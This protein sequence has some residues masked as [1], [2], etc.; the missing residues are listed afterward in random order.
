MREVLL[1]TII[2]QVSS[3]SE[4]DWIEQASGCRIICLL[5]NLGGKVLLVGLRLEL[6]QAWA[7]PLICGLCNRLI[8]L[9]L[10]TTIIDGIIVDKP[11]IIS[12]VFQVLLIILINIINVLASNDI[13]VTAN[14][15][16]KGIQ[17]IMMQDYRFRE[18]CTVYLGEPH[19]ARRVLELLSLEVC[20]S[21]RQ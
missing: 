18:V 12:L 1:C 20:L 6:Y 17:L 5:R 11:I 8:S 16:E 14:S 7:M 10:S 4:V 19:E 2:L 13:V 15:R 3:N 21:L 9:R